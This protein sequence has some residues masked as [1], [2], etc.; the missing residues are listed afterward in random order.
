MTQVLKN[1]LRTI[2][3]LTFIHS[4]PNVAFKMLSHV[5]LI[6]SNTINGARNQNYYSFFLNKCLNENI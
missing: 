5:N 6:L 4:K 2:S 1:K 3:V